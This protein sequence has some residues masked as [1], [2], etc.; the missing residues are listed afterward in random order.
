MI[1]Q[2]GKYFFQVEIILQLHC[3]CAAAGQAALFVALGIAAPG[4][5]APAARSADGRLPAGMTL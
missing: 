2:I 4:I 5:V 3:P 1:F